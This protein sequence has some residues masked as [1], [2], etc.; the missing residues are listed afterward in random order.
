MQLLSHKFN[1]NGSCRSKL[2]TKQIKAKQDH[3][4][5]LKQNGVHISQ[6][7]K[8]TKNNKCKNTTVLFTTPVSKILEGSFENV[9]ITGL[10]KTENKY[11][12]KN[13][14]GIAIMHKSN[15]VPVFSQ[16]SAVEI[17]QMRR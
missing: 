12:G 11:T 10:K 1:T 2:S 9:G 15:M 4:N 14:V 6:I 7:K 17:S 8:R 5:W 16:N 13:L 3:E